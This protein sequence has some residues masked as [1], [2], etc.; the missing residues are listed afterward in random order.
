LNVRQCVE[1]EWST[2]R[3]ESV[4]CLIMAMSAMVYEFHQGHPASTAARN[5]NSVYD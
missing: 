2:P 4:A 5:I 1:E 3:F